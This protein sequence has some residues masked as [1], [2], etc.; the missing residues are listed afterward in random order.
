MN[1]PYENA[2]H[3]FRNARFV[4]A[5]TGAGISV[6]SGIS[7]FRGAGGIW[8]K[9]PIEE[10]AVID[11]FLSNPKKVWDFWYEI[12][13]ALQD[14]Q[15]NPAHHAL[16]ELERQGVCRAVITQNIDDL[17]E[18]AGST[19]VIKY[20]G[21]AHHMACMD[22][23][24]KRPLDWTERTE[25]VPRCACGG[26]MKPDVVMFGEM[27]PPDAMYEADRLAR[28]CDLMIVVGTSAQVFPAAQL[29]YTAKD[30]GAFIIEANTE[31]TDF[32]RAITGAFLMG[33]AGQTLPKLLHCIQA[34]S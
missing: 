13:A 17:H 29:P 28:R 21:S 8:S 16:A 15:P 12:G 27:I 10:Y 4:V 23:G 1:D 31:K 26:L 22:C 19:H 30:N 5:V 3:A 7:S 20:H 6:E 14:C 24:Y 2:A 9:Y 11:A 32:T 33:P 34:H 25:L 18:K